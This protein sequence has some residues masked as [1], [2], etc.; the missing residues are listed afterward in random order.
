VEILTGYLNR[1]VDVDV[2]S[3][4]PYEASALNL[5]CLTNSTPNAIDIVRLLLE[6]TFKILL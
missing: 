1:G 6:V 5:V 3:D 4:E 2:T